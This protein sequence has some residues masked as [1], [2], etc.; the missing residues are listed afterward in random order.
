MITETK[1]LIR[2]AR[3]RG[4]HFFDEK[5]MR[6]FSSRVHATIHG[7]EFFITSE[8]DSTGAV[9]GGERR[10]TIRR[11]TITD[12]AV[13]FDT[14]GE[15]GQYATGQEASRAVRAMTRK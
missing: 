9:W 2:V 11:F 14:V 3:E 13:T 8:Q 1:E 10:Y 6:F 4:S 7:G 5:T 12:N 15:L